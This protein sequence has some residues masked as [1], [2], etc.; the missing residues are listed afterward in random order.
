MCLFA[1]GS[2]VDDGGENGA[3]EYPGDLV[4]IEKGEAEQPGRGPRIDGREGQSD[5]RHNEEPVPQAAGFALWR[6]HGLVLNPIA[7]N[8]IAR[9]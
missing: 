4:P 2:K 9:L 6:I 1:F 7:G 5:R 8:A 3:E